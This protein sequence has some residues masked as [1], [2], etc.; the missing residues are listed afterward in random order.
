M[1]YEASPSS[2][3]GDSVRLQSSMLHTASTIRLPPPSLRLSLI[4]SFVQRGSMWMPVV[5]R[6]EIEK[7]ASE[8]PTSPLLTAVLVAGSKLS[9]APNA[10]EYG[11]RCYFYTKSHFF[12]GSGASAL[13]LL[14][15]TIILNW[16][17]PAGP[18]HVSLDS[19]GLWLRIGV[20]LAHQLGL[21]REPD[22]AL[23]DARLRRRIWWTLV[24][25]CTPVSTG[26]S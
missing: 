25:S 4:S 26:F 14:T 7:L 6:N 11:E 24:V 22:P 10:L 13:R 15:I 2:T 8:S 17:N 9:A 1:R 20:G 18:E 21:H 16:W 19:S 12:L 3:A 23:P 5:D